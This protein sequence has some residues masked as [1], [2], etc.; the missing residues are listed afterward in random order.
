MTENIR[1][2]I[3][4][5]GI[6]AIWS[7]SGIASLHA[8]GGASCVAAEEEEFTDNVEFFRLLEEANQLAD[9]Y[10]NT[11]DAAPQSFDASAI[12]APVL[13]QDFTALMERSQAGDWR[14][15][16]ETFITAFN[17]MNSHLQ[18]K[19]RELF[20][21]GECVCP[22]NG[23][24]GTGEEGF[25]KTVLPVQLHFWYENHIFMENFKTP[26]MI[27]A[28]DFR[29]HIPAANQDS[30]STLKTKKGIYRRYVYQF[31]RQ[32]S[33]IQCAQFLNDFFASLFQI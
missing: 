12:P 3:K 30:N 28:D 10:L 20:G 24:Y 9:A 14:P 17:E 6:A 7:L 15:A 19:W 16:A 2:M 33:L 32:K 1:K 11:Q 13:E 26:T 29:D 23:G 4:A 18:A 25:I 31:F 22:W 5:A 21:E 8:G 27:Y